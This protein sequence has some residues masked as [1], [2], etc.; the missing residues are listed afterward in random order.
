MQDAQNDQ[1]S[2]QMVLVPS[3]VLQQ[4]QEGVA[5][6]QAHLVRQEL[7]KRGAARLGNDAEA[8]AAVLKI[9]HGDIVNAGAHFQV[10]QQLEIR[11]KDITAELSTYSEDERVAWVSQQAV[12]EAVA[13]SACHPAARLEELSGHL[14]ELGEVHAEYTKVTKAVLELAER[15]GVINAQL[16]ADAKDGALDSQLIAAAQKET[17]AVMAWLEAHPD[18]TAQQIGTKQKELVE[19]G[20]YKAYA[21]AKAKAKA[22]AEP[23][24]DEA[25]M[26]KIL[27]TS[28]SGEA[29]VLAL[30]AQEGKG[31]DATD[32]DRRSALYPAARHGDL[33]QLRALIG[34]GAS[35][36]LQRKG[37]G[38]TSLHGAVI[39]GAAGHVRALLAAGADRSIMN[40]YRE[41]ALDKAKEYGDTECV[42]ILQQ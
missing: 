41:T 22:K 2:P 30:L 25:F 11:C 16:D 42:Q 21:E 5:G 20:P 6:I 37:D 14:A 17:A 12:K 8:V 7:A 9:E 36:N 29:A 3:A 1:A 39:S 31:I 33:D 10:A 23:Y 19:V 35:L 28:K 27:E 15:V 4:L 32:S 34:A 24:E 40:K 26:E 13:W 38:C 18:A